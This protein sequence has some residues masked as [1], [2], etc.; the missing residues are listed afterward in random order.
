VELLPLNLLSADLTKPLTASA[1][2][3]GVLFC[4]AWGAKPLVVDSHPHLRHPP[5]RSGMYASP[6]P[7]EHCVQLQ[8]P[9]QLGHTNAVANSSNSK[10]GYLHHTQTLQFSRSSCMGLRESLEHTYRFSMQ[11]LQYNLQHCVPVDA[12]MRVQRI[13]GRVDLHRQ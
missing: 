1:S 11:E 12:L 7:R 3:P 2:R 9:R 13:F 5:F 8:K 6:R 10:S 4:G